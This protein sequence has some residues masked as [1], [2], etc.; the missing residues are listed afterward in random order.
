M[1]KRINIADELHRELAEFG[2]RDESYNTIIARV[3]EHTNKDEAQKDRMNRVTSYEERGRDEDEKSLMGNDALETLPDGVEVRWRIERGDYAGEERTG[4]VRG[5][6]IE[7]NGSTWTPSGFAREADRE[8][9]G[10]EARS[11]GSYA[12]PREVEYQND[13]GEWV[14]LHTVFEE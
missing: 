5:G 2:N 4:T 7:F 8:I 6:R 9:R 3:L 13:N 1:G 11:S 10:T 12:G 14:S